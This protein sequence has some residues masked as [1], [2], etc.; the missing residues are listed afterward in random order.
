MGK[1]SKKLDPQLGKRQVVKTPSGHTI[2]AEPWEPPVKKKSEVRPLS[3]EMAE[4]MIRSLIRLYNDNME[5]TD[6][7]FERIK[8]G[9]IA[10]VIA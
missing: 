6:A 7:D 4:R 9:I 3:P 2:I 5:I 8:K 10:R 1:K